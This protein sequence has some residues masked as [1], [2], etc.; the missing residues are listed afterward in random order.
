MVWFDCG[1]EVVVLQP[2]VLALVC[3]GKLSA[4]IAGSS[5]VLGLCF[6]GVSMDR[7]SNVV[8]LGSFFCFV[9]FQFVIFVWCAA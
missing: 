4:V 7:F 6:C 2:H 1:R 9:L 8:L 3:R 5:G